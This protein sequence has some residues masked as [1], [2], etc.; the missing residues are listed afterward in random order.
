M[1][2]MNAAIAFNEG[3]R[4]RQEALDLYTEMQRL[5]K[6]DPRR[7][8]LFMQLSTQHP[9]I[10]M[11]FD[12]FLMCLRMAV[13][14]NLMV[15]GRHKTKTYIEMSRGLEHLNGTSTT[16]PHSTGKPALSFWVPLWGHCTCVCTPNFNCATR[17]PRLPW[18]NKPTI[19]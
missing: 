16:P 9:V 19:L 14:S 1:T 18:I 15:S 7:M 5:R 8:G 3:R 13:Q 6:T 12:D 17:H 4:S 10:G 2:M 11:P